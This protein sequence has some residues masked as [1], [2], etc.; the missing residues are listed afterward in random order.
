MRSRVAA[1]NVPGSH[2]LYRSKKCPGVNHQ[3]PSL[4]KYGNFFRIRCQRVRSRGRIGTEELIDDVPAGR[5]CFT[6]ILALVALDKALDTEQVLRL[7]AAQI[8][9]DL[10]Q[11]KPIW[12]IRIGLNRPGMSG[13]L[14]RWK[15]HSHGTTE[16]VPDR[17][18]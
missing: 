13:E 18:A 14:I 15:D 3:A 17:V 7:C 2:L 11:S 12:R 10:N 1:L 6:A 5:R 4:R 16:Q 9:T 8:P